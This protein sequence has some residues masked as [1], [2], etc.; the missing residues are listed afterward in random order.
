L[1]KLGQQPTTVKSKKICWRAFRYLIESS[2]R[3]YLSSYS[4]GV[5][6]CGAK[7]DGVFA[8]CSDVRFPEQERRNGICP[9]GNAAR[10]T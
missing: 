1:S 10:L 7:F 9:S 3:T 6:L 4:G 2:R 8:Y 5:V